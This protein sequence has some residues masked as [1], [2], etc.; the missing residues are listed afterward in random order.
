MA[1]I[2]HDLVPEFLAF[3]DRARDLPPDE[4]ARA[5]HRLFEAHPAIGNDLTRQDRPFDPAR[6]LGLYP[7][8]HDRIV[9]NAP[10]VRRW[11][12]DAYAPVAAAFEADR[13]EVHGYGIVGLV[14]SNGW[15][16]PI[17]GAEALFLA[18]ERIPDEKAARLLGTH[19]MAHAIHGHLA[20]TDLETLGYFLFAEGFVTRLTME[21]MPE[22]PESEHLWFG[23][24]PD[25]WTDDCERVM[26]AVS[27][28]IAGL[29]DS[30][31]D[32]VHRRYLMR[33]EDTSVPSRIGYLIGLRA[34]RRLR[35]RYSLAEMARWSPDLA[36]ERLAG[37]L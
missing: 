15:S 13:I 1:V 31:D 18:V 2:V 29:L 19:E 25:G 5:W 36:V 27:A 22:Y 21:L 9:A 14:T 37:E 30:E 4:Q 12:E 11:I 26:G 16:A 35:R 24:E 34:V 8:L 20:G 28:E 3:W 7:G 33:T 32:A 10:H 6:A 17:A 23:P